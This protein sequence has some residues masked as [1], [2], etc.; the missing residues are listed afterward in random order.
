MKKL[1]ST[2]LLLIVLHPNEA[3]ELGEDQLGAW[4]MYSGTHRVTEKLSVDTAIQLW[5]YEPT[6]NFNLFLVLTGVEYSLTPN[7]ITS[8]GYGYATIDQSFENIFLE[9]RIK[10]HRLYEQVGVNNTIG[11]LRVNQRYRIEHRFLNGTN[12]TYLRHRN[13]YR[14]QLTLPLTD[15]FFVNFYDELFWHF[16]EKPFNQNRLY[17]ALGICM[18]A[19]SKLQLGYL[20]HHFSSKS[21]DR[22]QVSIA[23]KTDFRKQK[24]R[25]ASS[26]K[27]SESLD[28]NNSLSD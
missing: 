20:K 7:L 17:A 19:N 25:I 27:I 13:R 4:Y 18:T 12:T 10:E 8:I 9:N 5:D 1:V 6:N 14:L 16:E 11:K 2:L 3:Q 28:K 22:L 21:Y 15:T 24:N 23:I 26:Y